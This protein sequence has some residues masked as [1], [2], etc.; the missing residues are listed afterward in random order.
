MYFMYFNF[1]IFPLFH[2]STN[3]SYLLQAFHCTTFQPLQYYTSVVP[4]ITLY[5]FPLY[6]CILYSYRSTIIYY[7]TSLYNSLLFQL[8]TFQLYKPLLFTIYSYRS[9]TLQRLIVFNTCIV[10]NTRFLSK[11]LHVFH[12]SIFPH[13]P[14]S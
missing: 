5:T 9:I 2:H 11:I 1:I 3:T 8:Y 6:I 12:F 10:V 4:I 7:T 14:L 13:F